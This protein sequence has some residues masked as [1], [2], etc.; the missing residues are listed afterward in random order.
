MIGFNGGLIGV[1]KNYATVQ[2][3]AGVITL[4]EQIYSRHQYRYIRWRITA[5]RTAGGSVQAS[6][7]NLRAGSTNIAMSL[8][9]MSTDPSNAFGTGTE[10]ANSL[11]DANIN[12]KWNTAVQLPISVIFDMGSSVIFNGYRWA[13]ANDDSGRDPV[14]WTVDGSNNAVDYYTLDTQT[15]FATTTSRNT[16]VGPFTVTI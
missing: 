1:N 13:T 5:K 16:Y 3:N 11:K 6:E 8:A 9:I 7:F 4:G 2:S 12:S 14:T 15:N 10:T